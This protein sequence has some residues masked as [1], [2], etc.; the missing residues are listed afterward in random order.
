MTPSWLKTARIFAL[1]AW[2]PPFWP[3]VEV[4]WD[5][6]QRTMQRLE[7]D[8]L[9]VNALT[10]WATCPLPAPAYLPDRG[11]RD[12]V[13][14]GRAF[15][16][17]HGYRWILYCPLGTVMPVSVHASRRFAGVYQ[18]TFPTASAANQVAHVELWPAKTRKFPSLFIFGGEPCLPWCPLAM[19]SWY[20]QFVDELVQRYGDFDAGWIDGL[21]FLADACDNPCQCPTCR[22]E[23]RAATGETWPVIRRW[24]DPRLPA[25]QARRRR[26]VL[27]LVRR[28]VQAMSRGRTVPLVANA[29]Q[30]RLPALFPEMFAEAR[31]G[32]LFEHAPDTTDLVLKTSEAARLVG[33]ALVYPDCYDPWPRRVTSGWEVETKGLTIL[34]AGGTPYL[35][36]PGKYYYDDSNDEPARHIFALMRQHRELFQ[37]QQP[38]AAVGVVSLR[39]MMSPAAME[40]HVD[41]SRGW[42]QCLMDGHVPCGAF[43]WHQLDDTAALQCHQVLVLSSLEALTKWQARQLLRFVRA[44]GAVWIEGGCG[45]AATFDLHRP[46]RT[47][48]AQRRWAEYSGYAAGDDE[49]RCYDV[50]A[51]WRKNLHGMSRPVGEIHPAHL[52]ELVPGRSWQ[53][54]ADAVVHDGGPALSPGGAAVGE[55]TAGLERD[56]VGQSV[57]RPARGA[58]GAVDARRVGMVA[59]TAATGHYD[60]FAAIAFGRK[61]RGGWVV[62]VLDQPWRGWAGTPPQMVGDDEGRRCAAGS[63]HGGVQRVQWATGGIIVWCCARPDHR[64]ARNVAWRV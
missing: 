20:D 22:R 2:W 7:L 6:V 12:L 41:G 26:L 24:D 62:V 27:A 33:A 55:G 36:Q 34:G 13:A 14:E 48:A 40:F 31:D 49:L 9:Q 29:A 10:K 16:R 25:I 52:G 37:Q 64:Q 35:A 11:E 50:Y 56:A 18:P 61:P 17:R 30:P 53:V 15:A 44:G 63:R 1:E 59:D 60:G 3:K 5:R 45:S 54:I 21:D 51:S 46:R 38:V 43:P 42:T 28:T 8:T 19:R 58:I 39:A 23:H 4:D 57:S 32:G 47:P